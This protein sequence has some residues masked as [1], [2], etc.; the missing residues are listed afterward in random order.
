MKYTLIKGTYHVVGQSPDADSIKFKAAKDENWQKIDTEFRD[1]FERKFAEENGLVTLRLEGVDAV[2]TH[3]SP[4]PMQPPADLK[5]KK[6]TALEAPRPD[7]V[8]QPSDLGRVST[9]AFLELL[10]VTEAQWR[11]TGRGAYITEAKVTIGKKSVVVKEKLQDN[12]PGYIVTGDMEKNGR[13]VAWI[14]PGKIS[15]ADGA[16]ITATKLATLAKKSANYQLLRMGMVYPFFFMTLPGRLRQLLSEGVEAAQAAA[17]KATKTAK[18]APTNIWLL[19][20]STKGVNLER[21]SVITEEKAIYPYL[22]RKLIKHHL[23]LQMESYWDA[24]RKDRK[25]MDPVE[26]INLDHFFSD[27]NPYVFVISDQDF[28]R[29]ADVVS[30]S[31]STIKMKKSPHDLVFLS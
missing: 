27:A 3:Y 12:I 2:E 10:G 16:E 13:P 19:D 11:A 18:D 4:P 8:K 1:V 9:H 7:D 28:T 14:F 15:G 24:L 17:K 25:T 6:S 23:R 26:E 5:D 21:L 31:G 30:V 20:H 29:L 22:F